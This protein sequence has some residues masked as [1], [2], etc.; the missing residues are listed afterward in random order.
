MN[1][2]FFLENFHIC[3]SISQVFTG[4]CIKTTSK[5][6]SEINFSDGTFQIDYELWSI[7]TKQPKIIRFSLFLFMLETE[8]ESGHE[9]IIFNR[10]YN[11]FVYLLCV[12]LDRIVITRFCT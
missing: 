5:F 6:R 9:K 7:D 4:S 1:N 10:N 8:T 12:S 3:I 2:L 11:I